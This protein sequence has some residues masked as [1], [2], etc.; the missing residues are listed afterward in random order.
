MEGDGAADADDDGFSEYRAA[1][2]ARTPALAAQSPPYSAAAAAAA[3]AADP[4]A[5]VARSERRR[6]ARAVNRGADAPPE[7]I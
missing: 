4:R 2:P 6:L 5:V 3:A 1:G 7:A